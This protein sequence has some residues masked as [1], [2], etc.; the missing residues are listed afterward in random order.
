MDMRNCR[1][2]G[3]LFAYVNTPICP[4]CVKQDEDDFKRVKEYIYD[5]PKCSMAEVAQETQV[6]IK[7]ITKFLRDG[8]LEIVE[9]MNFIL[10][11]ESCGAPIKTGRFCPKCTSDLGNSIS[12][13]VSV[14]KQE[15]EINKEG[16][17][18]RMYTA[19]RY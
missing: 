14:S 13:S 3:K 8:R 16:R 19:D 12:G 11:C 15:I 18:P 9:G 1:R 2:C 4:N 10:E 7:K 17:K 6:S 5:H